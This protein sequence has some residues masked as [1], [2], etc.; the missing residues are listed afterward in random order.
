MEWIVFKQCLCSGVGGRSLLVRAP[1]L[2][3]GGEAVYEMVTCLD[4][5][6]LH[7]TQTQL[8][9]LRRKVPGLQPNPLIH[10]NLNDPILLRALQGLI[11]ESQ[12]ITKITK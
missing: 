8:Y 3:S 9:K 4:A 10:R 11:T 2:I 12:M 6:L 7:I 5:L 1:Q